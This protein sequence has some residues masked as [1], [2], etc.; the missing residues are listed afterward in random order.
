MSKKGGKPGTVPGRSYNAAKSDKGFNLSE[1][2]EYAEQE[3][4]LNSQANWEGASY[5]KKKRGDIGKRKVV[6][7]S[8]GCLGGGD[9]LARGKRRIG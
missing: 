4:F 1:E 2:E 3:K 7:D 5:A 8:E 9:R 6:R